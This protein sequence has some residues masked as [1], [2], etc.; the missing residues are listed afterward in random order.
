[1]PFRITNSMMVGSFNR[2][3]MSNSRKMEQLQSQLATNKKNVRL[4]DDA[5]SVVKIV[6]AKAK[7]NDATQYTR[8][9]EDAETW[10]NNTETALNEANVIIKRVYELAV[11]AA[12]D[13]LGLDERKAIALEVQQ[14]RDQVL[15]LANATLGEKFIFGGYNVTFPPFDVELDPDNPDSDTITLNGIDMIDDEGDLEFVS[16]SI[17]LGVDF[18]V[19]LSGSAF[20]GLG[21]NENMWFQFNE[22]AKELQNYEQDYDSL[23]G[24]IPRLQQIQNNI[25]T[26]LAEVGGRTARIALMKDR[27]AVDT[28]NYTQMLSDAQDLDQAEGIMRFTMAEAV[29]RAALNVGGRILP[30]T[31]VDFMR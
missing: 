3:L 18:E 5:V 24:F 4:S 15:T 22:F 11:Y 31:L 9:L 8:N 17:G 21:E 20:M 25:L 26:N 1:M 27:Y 16:Y 10:L 19:A 30:P 12:N 14:L 6:N 29:Y 23:S 13:P 7:Q 2:N 28:I